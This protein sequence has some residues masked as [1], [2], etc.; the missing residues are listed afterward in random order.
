MRHHPKL[1]K[2]KECRTNDYFVISHTARIQVI[3][4]LAETRIELSY[5]RNV[6]DAGGE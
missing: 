3:Y 2:C 1:T 4:I 6:E 5:L